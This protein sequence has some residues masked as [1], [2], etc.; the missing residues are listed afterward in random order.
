MTVIRRKIDREVVADEGYTYN[1]YTGIFHCKAAIDSDGRITIRNAFTP[2][3]VADELIE[4]DRD[5]TQA[6]FELMK[7]ISKHCDGIGKL[8]N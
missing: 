7:E 8:P 6:I 2:D 3:D 5:E 1:N 4:L